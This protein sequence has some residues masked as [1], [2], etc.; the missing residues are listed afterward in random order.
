MSTKKAHALSFALFLIG[1]AI[2]TLT[3]VWWPAIM[4]VIGLPLALRQRLLGRIYD[5]IV[6]LV[7]FVGIFITIQ[8]KV[9]WDVLVPVLFTV[10]GLYIFFRE[11][12]SP[13]NQKEL[14]NSSFLDSNLEENPKDNSTVNHD[15]EDE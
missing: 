13:K 9:K 3:K 6:T 7:V 4:L 8:F 10:G 11:F 5:T 14:K 15:N 1:L 2:L 12:F